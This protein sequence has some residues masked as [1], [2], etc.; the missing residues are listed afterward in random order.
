MNDTTVPVKL[1]EQDAWAIQSSVKHD[2]T[3][4]LDSKEGRAAGLTLR[5]KVN[6][7]IV[8]YAEKRNGDPRPEGVD[9]ALTAEELWLID[10]QLLLTYA[11]ARELLVRVFKALIKLETASLWDQEVSGVP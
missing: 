1:T 9:I 3:V 8:E 7:L 11:G 6:S 4:R 2:M 10:K 5:E